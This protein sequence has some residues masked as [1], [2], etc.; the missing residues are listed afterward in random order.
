MR[1]IPRDWYSPLT[2][3]TTLK[4]SHFAPP[5]GVGPSVGIEVAVG[6]GVDVA[7]RVGSGVNVFVGNGV[8]VIGGIAVGVS[9]AV[10]GFTML[11]ID[12]HPARITLKAITQLYFRMDSLSTTTPHERPL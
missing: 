12:V 3:L 7:V 11:A 2:R 9:V 4:A 1:K 10:G 6:S 8:S 5:D